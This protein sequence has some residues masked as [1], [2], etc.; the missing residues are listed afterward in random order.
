MDL[1]SEP[2][3]QGL[4]VPA[5]LDFKSIVSKCTPGS[6]RGFSSVQQGWE[7][8]HNIAAL[9]I[10]TVL[11]NFCII[12]QIFALGVNFVEITNSM[13]KVNQTID[14]LHEIKNY[15]LLFGRVHFTDYTFMLR[16][17]V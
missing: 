13:F 6:Y 16:K 2:N 7:N 5:N 14:T 8:A 12:F 4:L 17:D 1:R 3:F 10:N 9:F 15:P 11:Y